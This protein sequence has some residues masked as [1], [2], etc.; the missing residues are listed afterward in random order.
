MPRS[1][2]LLLVVLLSYGAAVASPD[3]LLARALALQAEGNGQEALRLLGDFDAATPAAPAHGRLLFLR[4][5]LYQ[6]HGNPEAALADF[7]RVFDAYP[8]LA[9]YAA[10]ELV[11]GPRGTGPAGAPPGDGSHPGGALPLQPAL[12]CLPAHPGRGAGP[13]GAGGGGACHA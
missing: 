6:R 5:L 7:Q 9:D 3:A 11:Q 13:A 4:A 1:L 2:C 12:A 10:W 8:P